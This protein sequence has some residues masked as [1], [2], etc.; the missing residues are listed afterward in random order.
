MIG[1]RLRVKIEM[2]NHTRRNANFDCL[3]FA[4]SDRQY[5]RRV[6]AVAP[7]ETAERNIDWAEGKNLIGKR[8]LLRAIE[9][10][11]N[12]VINYTFEVTR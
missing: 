10:E 1:E 12:R 8:L 6:L 7:N 4:G 11:G 9:Q 2:T 3:L 5:E